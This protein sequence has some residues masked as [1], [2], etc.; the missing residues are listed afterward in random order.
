MTEDNLEQRIEN[1]E[2][3]LMFQDDLIEQLN[4]SLIEQ[5][6]DIRKLTLMVERMS[7]QLEDIQQPL[8]AD[9]SEETPPPH[10]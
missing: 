8:I 2:S 5:H 4:Q 1:L 10:Y 9:A 7:H 6:L 3:R